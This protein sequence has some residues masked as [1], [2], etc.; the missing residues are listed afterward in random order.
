MTRKAASQTLWEAQVKLQSKKKQAKKDY[1]SGFH[2]S[3]E[4]KMAFILK[5][6]SIYYTEGL[7][8]I[9]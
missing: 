7:L 6:K 9:L 3:V 2:S 1:S 5:N 4:I 8:V